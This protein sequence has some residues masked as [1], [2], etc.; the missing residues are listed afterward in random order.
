M[1]EKAT[2]SQKQKQDGQ[3]KLSVLHT[4][5]SLAQLIPLRKAA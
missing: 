5:P 3:P 2:Q 4:K 1:P